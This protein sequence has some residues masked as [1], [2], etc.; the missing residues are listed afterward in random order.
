M[1]PC[2]EGC[3]ESAV[4]GTTS[5]AVAVASAGDA[6]AEGVKELLGRKVEVNVGRRGERH[7]NVRCE[8][9]EMRGA[10]RGR[11]RRMME[12]I[13]GREESDCVVWVW[14]AQVL[15]RGWGDELGG[16]VGRCGLRFRGF[17]GGGESSL[18]LDFWTFFW[19]CGWRR[20][21]A[22]GGGCA[23]ICGGGALKWI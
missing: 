12:C 15:E 19:S 14:R 20:V 8:R 1:A 9:G 2:S 7:E 6:A 18:A 10:S 17:G 11:A 4:L 5:A 21:A 22:A 16:F 23:L 13:V 3:I